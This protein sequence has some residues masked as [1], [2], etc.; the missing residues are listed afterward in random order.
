M[1][2]ELMKEKATK[3]THFLTYIAALRLTHSIW[4]HEI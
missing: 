2:Y 3:D 4:R 1:V